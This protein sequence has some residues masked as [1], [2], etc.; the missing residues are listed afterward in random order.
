METGERQQPVAGTAYTLVDENQN[1]WHVTSDGEVVSGPISE[2]NDENKA[3]Y[4][5]IVAVNTSAVSDPED[6]ET[7]NV[8][9]F[10]ISSDVP[11]YSFIHIHDGKRIALAIDG[12]TEHKLGTQYLGK[13]N[14]AG[15]NYVMASTLGDATTGDGSTSIFEINDETQST[16]IYYDLRGCRV[17]A[18]VKGGIYVTANGKKVIF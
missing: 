15:Q 6:M 3:F 8:Q 9:T 1:A 14:I 12:V 2:M 7:E 11:A 5:W 17:I 13:V 10:R 4:H 18:P 16:E